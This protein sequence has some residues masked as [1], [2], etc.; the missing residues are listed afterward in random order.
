MDCHRKPSTHVLSSC[1]HKVLCKECSNIIKNNKS[2]QKY[3]CPLCET[4][5][6][7][8]TFEYKEECCVICLDCSCDCIF[9]PCDH[10]WACF[11]YAQRVMK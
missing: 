5:N 6:S 10:H 2:N 7:D 4:P 8:I 3:S 11:E 1:S 9:L